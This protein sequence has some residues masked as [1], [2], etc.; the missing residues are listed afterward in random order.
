MADSLL[1]LLY[2]DAPVR[3]QIVQLR[4]TWQQILQHHD[5]PGPVSRL[6]GELTAATA[7]LASN[8][9]FNGALILQI[10]GDGPVKLMVVECQPDLT[11]RATA[12]LRS[13]AKIGALA[14]WRDLVNAGGKGRCAIT[15]DPRERL[16]GQ[17]PYQGIVALEGDTVAQAIE[18]YMRQSEQLETRLWLAANLRTS[19]GVLLQKL[20]A[21]QV[22]EPAD[23]ETWRRATVLGS[24]LTA[25][26]LLAQTPATLVRR[27]FWQEQM[28]PAESLA[29]RF[30]CTCSRARI[31]RMLISLGR[32]EVESVVADMGS[33]SVTC[34]FCGARHEFDR[35]DVGHLFATGIADAGPDEH[36]DATRQ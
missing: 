36:P 10:H 17:Q 12:K 32:D 33:V 8:I 35:V 18:N 29:P 21:P 9:K 5:Y 27:L 1:K 25:D 6:L 2:R 28:M 20:P 14:G 11:L 34:D 30:L 26:E 7:L 19:A 24:T 22:A 23:D 15:L 3:A 13:G 31:G 4:H 16:P